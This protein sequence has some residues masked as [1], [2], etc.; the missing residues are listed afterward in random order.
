MQMDLFGAPAPANRA[1]RGNHRPDLPLLLLASADHS[2]GPAPAASD[3]ALFT[4]AGRNASPPSNAQ[5][6]D[7]GIYPS[8]DAEMLILP[9]LRKGWQGC[10][11]AEIALL[12]VPQGWLASVG[13]QLSG[14][15]WRG[16]GYGLSPKW[17]GGF[18]PSRAAAL[19]HARAALLRK[20]DGCE[21]KEAQRVRDWLAGLI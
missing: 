4:H 8:D 21:G 12:H 3:G 18:L 17:Q 9:Y 10:P 6:N 13:Y 1:A 16:G 19:D 5:P 11:T 14:G 20:V 15:D 7:H 2:I